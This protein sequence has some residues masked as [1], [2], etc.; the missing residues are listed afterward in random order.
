MVRCARWALVITATLAGNHCSG[1]GDPAKDPGTAIVIVEGDI[2]TID[3]RFA[4]TSH[5]IKIS[6]LVFSGLTTADTR[7][8]SIVPDL[9]RSV[10]PEDEAGLSWRVVLREGLRFHDGHLVTSEDVVYTYRSVM[11][12]ATGSRYRSTYSYVTSVKALDART[13]RFT[14]SETNASFLPDLTM[15]ILPAHVLKPAGGRFEDGSMVGSG[16]FR[17]ASRR[18]GR[19]ELAAFPD[20]PA[21][22]KAVRRVIFLTV[23]DDNARV[24]RLRGGGADL[25]QN[26]IP[27]HLLG[28]FDGGGRTRMLTGP[29]SSFTYLGLNLESD[30]VDDPRVREALLCAIDREA[31]VEHKLDGMARVSTGM[32]PFHHWAYSGNVARHP[33]DPGRARRLLDEAGLPDPDGEGPKTRFTL[34]FKTSS[35]RF[36][37]AVARVVAA[38]WRDVGIDVDLRP[39]E[40]STLRA[41]L[42]SGSYQV[43]FMEIPMV[44]EPNLYRWFFHS[45]SIPGSGGSGGANR[46]RYKSK[47]ADGLMDSGVKVL[48]AQARKAVYAELQALLADDLPVLPLWHEDAVAVTSTRL[49]GY[50]LLGGSPYTPLMRATLEN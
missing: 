26:N 1:R 43:T 42:D 29:G 31:I 32:L 8:L 34:V 5:E 23:R 46:W 35:A 10:E 9:A 4:S 33:Y 41:H 2:G 27:V 16:P 18:A 48:D 19:I 20:P 40:F 50:E 47:Q 13:V 3:P 7:D 37:V 15:P 11:D 24:L 36:R 25:S 21:G 12:P 38:A 22:V 6:R 28:L 39:F 30:P 17:L 49:N 44:I 45:T 14:L